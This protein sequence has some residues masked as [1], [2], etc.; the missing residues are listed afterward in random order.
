MKRIR[1]WAFDIL[2]GW[3][4]GSIPLGIACGVVGAFVGAEVAFSAAG[5]LMA[6][7]SASCSC[8]AAA[9]CARRKR[10]VEQ[11]WSTRRRILGRG[12]GFAWSQ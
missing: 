12:R 8:D 4:M 9:G 10:A 5:V 2:V 3:V 6:R 11:N 7:S 1:G